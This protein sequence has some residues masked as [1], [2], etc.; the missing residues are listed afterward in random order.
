[1]I[2]NVFKMLSYWWFNFFILILGKFGGV[3]FKMYL[4][5]DFEIIKDYGYYVIV[6]RIE[7][8]FSLK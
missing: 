4:N 6:Y 8:I 1:M 5:D 7:V 3:F 2:I